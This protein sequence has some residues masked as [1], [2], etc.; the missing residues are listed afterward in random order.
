MPYEDSTYRAKELLELV[1]S[2]VFGPIKQP[3][4]SGF[5]Y[6]IIFIDDFSRYVWVYF[7]KEKLEALSKFMEFKKKVEKEVNRR[8]HYLCTDNGGKYTSLEFSKYL[9]DYKMR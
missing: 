8:I 3:S 6:M 9:Q 4:I 7:M 5:R 1:Y 2:D